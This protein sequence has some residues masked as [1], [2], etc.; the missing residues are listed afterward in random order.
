MN[1]TAHRRRSRVVAAFLLLASGA[2]FAGCANVARKDPPDPRHFDI[3]PVGFPS[4]VRTIRM[5]PQPLQSQAVDVPSRVRPASR[6]EPINVLALSG[7]GAG[8]AFGAGVLVGWSREGTRPEFQ[9][10]TGVSVGALIAPFA[11]LGPSWDGQLAEA[12]SGVKA[13]HLLQRRWSR[14]LFGSSI[15]RGEPLSA[16]V[17]SYVTRELVHAIAVAAANGRLLLVATTNLDT[18]QTVIWNLTAVAAQGGEHAR[19]LIRDVLIAAASIPGAFP[20]VMI[21]VEAS[22][23]SFDE[24]HVDGATTTSIIAGPE[25]G[26]FMRPPLDSLLGAHLYIIVNGQLGAVAQ[27]T[28]IKT[29]GIIK[30]GL[31]AELRSS[32]RADFAIVSAVAESNGMTVK[33]AEIPSDYP[34][35][36]LLDLQPSR[37]RALFDFAARCAELEQLWATPIE[38]QERTE[39]AL[40]GRSGEMAQCPARTPW[41]A[42]PHEALAAPREWTAMQPVGI[43][44]E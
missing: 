14:V 6:N 24:M 30:R 17:D 4:S 13:E 41:H 34:Y 19:K 16:L 39:H 32:A 2:L 43:R 10:V 11:F 40:A 20:P 38:V 8:G 31:G 42:Q 28:P 37:M 7:G 44:P 29:L 1:H 21:R 22:G 33:A 15:Y 27:R 12:F 25:I 18:E 23:Q 3:V 36:D 35:R 5:L 26:G 9:V